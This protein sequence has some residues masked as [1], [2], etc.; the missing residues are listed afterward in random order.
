[1]AEHQ[2][3]GITNPLSSLLQSS[4]MFVKHVLLEESSIIKKKLIKQDMARK[5]ELKIR[6]FF[7]HPGD[8][9]Q[10]IEMGT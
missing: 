6:G 1:M 3:S 10:G 9:F 2:I 4:I 7:L 5:K 8:T